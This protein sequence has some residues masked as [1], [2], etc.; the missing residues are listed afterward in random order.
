MLPL[1]IKKQQVSNN[2]EFFKSNSLEI[3]IRFP[4]DNVQNFKL[5][6]CIL[7]ISYQYMYQIF[8]CFINFP[9][10]MRTFWNLIYE[11]LR[12]HQEVK[13]ITGLFFH[14]VFLQHKC[15]EPECLSHQ[16]FNFCLKIFIDY[17]TIIII[18]HMS[19]FFKL[20]C[21]T[22]YNLRMPPPIITCLVIP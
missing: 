10:F 3:Y 22:V 8:A 16:I 17:S 20:I 9:C 14:T 21:S 1:N 6:L 15:D 2:L 12:I 18:V 11:D 4:R 7:P 13:R 5:I 19:L